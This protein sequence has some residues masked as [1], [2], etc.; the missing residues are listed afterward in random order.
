MPD[1]PNKRGPQDRSRISQP[2]HE[3]EYQKRKSNVNADNDATNREQNRQD[4]DEEGQGKPA[5]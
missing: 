1:D 2:K 4:S 3:Q 5:R